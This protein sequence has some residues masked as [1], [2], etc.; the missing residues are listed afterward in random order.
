MI[1][2]VHW[3]G[4]TSWFL[5]TGHKKHPWFPVKMFPKQAIQWYAVIFSMCSSFIIPKKNGEKPWIFT[6]LEASFPKNFPKIEDWFPWFPWKSS[7]QAMDNDGWCGQAV[8]LPVGDGV[9]LEARQ[10]R[11]WFLGA[12]HADG[13]GGLRAARQQRWRDGE[14]SCFFFFAGWWFGCHECYFPIHIGFIIIPIDFHIFQRDSNH[15]PVCNWGLIG[16]N[17]DWNWKI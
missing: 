13:G 12:K 16:M 6:Y 14:I 10:L 2:Y 8:L 7:L 5:T 11:P 1:I 9:A 4:G 3:I 15:Q 17:S